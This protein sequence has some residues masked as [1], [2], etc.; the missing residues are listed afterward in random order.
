MII[1]SHY[2]LDERMLSIEALIARMDAARLDRIACIATLNNPLPE[3]SPLLVKLAHF[4]SAHRLT[5]ILGRLMTDNFTAY[6]SI[7]L[8]IG[9]YRVYPNPGIIGDAREI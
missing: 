6:G 5:R 4:T 2:H 7:K 1:D 8:P 9:T 3:P